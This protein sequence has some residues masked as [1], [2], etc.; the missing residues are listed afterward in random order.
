MYTFDSYHPLLWLIMASCSFDSKSFHSKKIP[1]PTL[2]LIVSL[3]EFDTEQ[4]TLSS[5]SLLKCLASFLKYFLSS[6][7]LST[8]FLFF[9]PWFEIRLKAD[10][11]VVGEGFAITDLTARLIQAA[12]R[13]F[14]L[15][16]S[17][18]SCCLFKGMLPTMRSIISGSFLMSTR[19]FRRR[20][21]DPGKLNVSSCVKV[22]RIVFLH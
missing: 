1:S 18:S 11:I 4:L 21:V 19:S 3:A 9:G 16:T 15:L 13:I 10:D 6:F 12:R 20:S 2:N 14:I 5:T 8:G 17:S 22:F 7:N